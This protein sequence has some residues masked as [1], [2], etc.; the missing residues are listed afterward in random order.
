MKN[1]NLC[2]KSLNEK[3]LTNKDERFDELANK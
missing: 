1:N 3:P 2:E